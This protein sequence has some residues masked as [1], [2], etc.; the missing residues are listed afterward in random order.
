MDIGRTAQI[1]VTML[2]PTIAIGAALYAPRVYRAARRLVSPPET[3][4]RPDG[5]PIEEVA[6]DLR[7]LLWQHDRV[8][9]DAGIARRAQRLRALEAAITDC[10]YEAARA[11]GVSV[12]ERPR[13]STAELRK[14]LLSLADA[15][16]VL[17]PAVSLIAADRRL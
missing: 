3:A 13:L 1:V 16:L 5:R 4:P 17:P 8:R 14:L 10:A 9:R 11:L 7:R 12:P 15:G 2:S 6:G